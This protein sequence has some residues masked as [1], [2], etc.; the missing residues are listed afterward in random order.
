MDS[1]LLEPAA[2]STRQEFIVFRAELVKLRAADILRG[3]LDIV[4]GAVLEK[5]VK[6][7][8]GRDPVDPRPPSNQIMMSQESMLK[9]PTIGCRGPN[10]CQVD[11]RIP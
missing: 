1:L 3:G 9:T 11:W 2:H 5:G 7:V 10:L 4:E 8:T 6:G